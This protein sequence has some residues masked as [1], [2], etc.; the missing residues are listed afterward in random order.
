MRKLHSRFVLSLA[1]LACCFSTVL[2]SPSAKK[3]PEWKPAPE[4]LTKLSAP[5]QTEIGSIRVPLGFERRASLQKPAPKNQFIWEITSEEFGPERTLIL[6]KQPIP[7]KASRNYTLQRVLDEFFIGFSAEFENWKET[8]TQYGLINGQPA[9]RV[10]WSGMFHAHQVEMK[11]SLF[12]IRQG[13]KL[14]T[15]LCVQKSHDDEGVQLT[16]AA[17]LTF[18]PK[19]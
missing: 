8:P 14:F 12:A 3:L 15:I 18:K 2:A 13:M 7:E 9:V 11:G 16:E 17:A 19:P 5:V 10:R 6:M 1:V 4:L